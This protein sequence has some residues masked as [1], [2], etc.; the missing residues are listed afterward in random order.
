[1]ISNLTGM[2]DMNIIHWS[3]HYGEMHTNQ[4]CVHFSVAF[5]H[6]VR[7]SI[8]MWISYGETN[9]FILY[10]VR[11][12]MLMEKLFTVG[13]GQVEEQNWAMRVIKG[14]YV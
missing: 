11:F 4:K 2:I 6:C 12:S 9:T 13:E 14:W 8:G 7:F 3:I 1:M 5:F 10:C